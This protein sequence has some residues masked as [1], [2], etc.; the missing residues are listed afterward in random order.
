MLP[1]ENRLKKKKDFEKIFKKGKG[2]KES[3]LFLKILKNNLKISR[4]GFVVSGKVSKKATVRNKTKRKLRETIRIN[5]C[6]I[7]PGFDGI[8][9]V[10]KGLEVKKSP[11]IKEIIDNLLKKAKLIKK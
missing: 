5:L 10:N 11:E 7:K 9:L 6:R 4:F 1:K 8:F 3:F 2:F